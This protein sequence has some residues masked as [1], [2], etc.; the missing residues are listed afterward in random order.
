[1]LLF[2]L[3]FREKIVSLAIFFSEEKHSRKAFSCDSSAG[4]LLRLEG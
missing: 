4:E 3:H 1:M 2:A